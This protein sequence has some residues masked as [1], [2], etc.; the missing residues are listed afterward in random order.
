[1][2]TDVIDKGTNF[3]PG[4]WTDKYD[5]TKKDDKELDIFMTFVVDGLAFRLD[6][7]GQTIC[8]G[9]VED[10]KKGGSGTPQTPDETQQNAPEH[11]CN[12][13]QSS[14]P[15]RNNTPHTKRGLLGQNNATIT[16]KR[17]AVVQNKPFSGGILQHSKRGRPLKKKNI[18]RATRWRRE[19]QGVLL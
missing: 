12:T 11:F 16:H 13:P 18:S 10:L 14:K 19:K 3:Q 1:M 2:P 9:K 4:Y 7:K 15:P 5:K 17:R 6:E 8:C